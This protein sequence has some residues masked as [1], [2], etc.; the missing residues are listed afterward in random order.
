MLAVP[1]DLVYVCGTKFLVTN[2]TRTPI[3][4]TYRVAGTKETGGMTLAEGPGGDPGYSET[5]LETAE[6]GTVEVLQ[7]DQVIARRGNGGIPCGAPALSASVGAAGSASGGSWTA[8][9]PWPVVAIHVSL[10]PNGKVLS[11]GQSGQPQV[12]NPA[13]GAFTEVPE[14]V[15]IFCGG[16]ALL[17]D[18][19]LLVA[20]GHISDDHGLPDITI[21]TP[22][23][24]SW[25]KSTRM[26]RGRWYPSTTILATGEALIMAGR[27]EAGS[28]VTEPEVWS[29]GSLRV[30]S[31]APRTLPYYPRAF[32]APNG[33]VFYAGEVRRTRY[34][35]ATGSGRWTLVGD[36]RYGTRDYGSAVMYDEGKILYTGGGRTTNTAEI[37]D[38]T[39]ASPTWEWTGSMAYRRR[40]HTATVLPTGEV[41]V[42]GGSQGAGFDDVSQGVHAAEIWNPA[43]GVWRTVASNAVTRTY[44]G[45]ALLLPDGRVLHAGSGSR[46]APNQKNAELYSPPYLSQGTRPTISSAPAQVSY[47]SSFSVSTAQ[48]ASISSVS[49]IRLGSVTHAFDMNQRFQRLSFTKRSGALTISA[50]ADRR[51]TPPGHYMLFILNENR[52]PSVARIV[53]IS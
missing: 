42:T 23:T 52:V 18:G 28:V 11:W 6:Q 22:G 19:R 46:T 43:T 53:R 3:H 24:Q 16:H 29:S 15:E 35:D 12:W 5:E 27:D 47:G 37:I 38:L 4:V 1:I 30:L 21:F 17:P 7:D 20:G 25:T 26:R 14:P 2:S 50:P 39:K 48:A 49:L 31:G 44:H 32:L 40:H 13:T 8:P 34:L 51:R 41:L 10:L 45:T 9:F 33:R 36:R